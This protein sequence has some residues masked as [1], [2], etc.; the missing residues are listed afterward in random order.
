MA[1]LIDVEVV[2]ATA[3]EQ[4]VLALRV[5]AGTTVRQA[6]ATAPLAA[7]FPELDPERC[8]VGIF[9]RLCHAD[10]V[11]EEG[12]RVEIYRPLA[13]DPKQVRRERSRRK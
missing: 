1:E 4:A 8:R 5:P 3:Q 11:L 9:G 13:A 2:Y 12:D 10:Q 6:I 7:R